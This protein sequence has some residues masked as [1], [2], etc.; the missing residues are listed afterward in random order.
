MRVGFHATPRTF[1]HHTVRDGAELIRTTNLLIT[2][3]RAI[4]R[5]ESDGRKEKR[6]VRRGDR[7]RGVVCN[8]VDGWKSLC[9]H[10]HLIETKE[11]KATGASAICHNSLFEERRLR[12]GRE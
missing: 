2:H 11:A 1:A 4:L 3:E 6:G 10:T 12:D 5:W 9:V 7:G 8:A